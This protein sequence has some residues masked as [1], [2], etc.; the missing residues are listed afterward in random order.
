MKNAQMRPQNAIKLAHLALRVKNLD[1]CI[2]FYRDLLGMT[3]VWQPDDD[4]VYLS[5]GADNLALH[6]VP[7]NIGCLS[8]T[9]ALDHLGFV[10]GT[11]EEVDYWY[12]Y[13]S[14]NK[15]IL[16]NKPKIHRDGTKSFYCE[17]PEGNIIQ[18]ICLS[19]LSQP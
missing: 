13:L 5:T 17:D 4:N 1:A 14:D 10:L 8:C 18:M 3:I 15:V 16:K 6:R 12:H 2:S 19:S 7:D 9:Q 11:H